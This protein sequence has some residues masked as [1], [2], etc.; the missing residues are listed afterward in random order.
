MQSREQASTSDY[1]TKTELAAMLRVTTRTITNYVSG[2]ALPA[3]TKVGRK[4][5]WHREQ[6]R[7]F[8]QQAGAAAQ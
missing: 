7:S 6:L 5:L 1:V 2:G 8:L 4:A 3:P